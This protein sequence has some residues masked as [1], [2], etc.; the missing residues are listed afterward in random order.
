MV[1]GPEV[2]ICDRCIDDASGIVTSDVAAPS[3]PAAPRPK[4][5]T[6]PSERMTP[7][8]IKSSLDEYVVG[9]DQAKKALSVAVYNHYKRID[10]SEYF[11]EYEDVE[12]E[13][14]NILLLGPTGTERPYWLGRSPGSSMCLFPS[15][16]LRH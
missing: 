12:L 14:S 5:T 9:Q 1:A 3:A 15:L 10:S 6:A 16:T 13:K 4:R 2:Y 8:E 11:S 7:L